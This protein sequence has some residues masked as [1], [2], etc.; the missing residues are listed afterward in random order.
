MANDENV[1]PADSCCKDNVNSQSSNEQNQMSD[2]KFKAKDKKISKKMQLKIE[3]EK[4][5]R[6]YVELDV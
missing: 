3:L 5:H 2:V 4:E 6:G 1:M